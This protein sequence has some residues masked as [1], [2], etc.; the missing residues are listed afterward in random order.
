[1]K[2]QEK[3]ITEFR[4][5]PAVKIEPPV[6]PQRIVKY[7][8]PQIQQQI[9]ELTKAVRSRGFDG[10]FDLPIQQDSSKSCQIYF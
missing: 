1:M 9:R 10:L 4:N 3:V 8:E 7:E 6:S 2:D 5:K